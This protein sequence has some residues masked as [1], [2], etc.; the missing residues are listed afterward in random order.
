[1]NLMVMS[2]IYMIF[3][4]I[5]A[6]TFGGGYAMIPLFHAQLVDQHK[7]IS[8]SEFGNIVAIAQMTPG[9]IGINAA[10]YIGYNHGGL[11]GATIG[12]FGLLTPSLII[13]AIVAHFAERFQ[14]SHAV[15]GA[16]SGIRP[17]VI[18][19]IAGAV[20]F[21]AE[22]SIFTG[23]IPWDYIWD[24]IRNVAE[25]APDFGIRWQGIVIFLVALIASGKFKLGV[26]WTISLSAVLG[27]LL[28]SL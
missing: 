20:L 22:M 6:L 12:T 16:L 5:G 24:K 13:I 4:E 3:V 28:M 18:G 11:I 25:E 23:S 2:K 19:L 15:K 8:A 7:L 21:F 10:T 1:M 9:A 17:T 26:I 14:H 27:I